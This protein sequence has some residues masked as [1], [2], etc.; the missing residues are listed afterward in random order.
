MFVDQAKIKA[1]AGAGGNGCVSFHR[2]KFIQNGGP[3]GGDGGDGGSVILVGDPQM[4]TLM[5][6]RY[7]SK[8]GAESGGDGSSS[9]RK[10]KNGGCVE[11]RVPLGT[12][13]RTVDGGALLADIRVPDERRVILRG[14]RGGWGNARFAT[15]TRQA[16]NFAKPGEKTLWVELELE[17]KLIADVGLIG[18][19]NAGKSTLLSVVSA[20]KPKIANYPFTTLSPNIGMVR[21]GGGDFVLADLPGLIEGAAG[22]SGLGHA[23]LR[24]AE[25]TRLLVHVVD[26]SGEEG[27]DPVDDYRI[28]RGE[29]ESFSQKRSVSLSAKAQVIVANKI[30][31]PDAEDN[32]ARLREAAGDGHPVFPI[33]A[34]RH[35]GLD[36]LLYEIIRVL[37][38]LPEP[39]MELEAGVDELESVAPSTGFEITSEDGAYFAEGPGMRRL[40][41]SVNFSDQESVAWFHRSLI[42]LGVIDALRAAGAKEGD[43][44]YIEEQE[45]DFVD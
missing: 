31:R 16:P 33:S 6:F 43:T 34:M 10:G 36:A 13:V 22:G 2:E 28:I 44:V 19:P 38:T 41:D 5:D 8:Y 25:R 3:D 11:I 30:D 24:H 35:E 4:R 27:R 15:P 42:K 7:K 17:L 1:R 23:F 29:L 18:F 9:N 32:L 21:F 14:G 26:V 20:A 12:L 39:A 40:V 37:P 45:F